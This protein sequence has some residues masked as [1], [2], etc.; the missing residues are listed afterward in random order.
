[1]IFSGGTL[2]LGAQGQLKQDNEIGVFLGE[3]CWLVQTLVVSCLA[4]CQI[5]S[6]GSPTHQNKT[7]TFTSFLLGA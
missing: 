7:V 3:L 5:Y 2:I 6:T 4:Y 1:M